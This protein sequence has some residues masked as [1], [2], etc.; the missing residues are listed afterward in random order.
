M[1]DSRASEGVPK[2]SATPTYG[3]TIDSINEPVGSPPE[4]SSDTKTTVEP[5]LN[6]SHSV[7]PAS[8]EETARTAA[9]DEE[10]AR[11]AH[12]QERQSQADARLELEERSRQAEARM[13][14]QAQEQR[15]R[16][17]EQ[18]RRV[19]RQ[20]QAEQSRYRAKQQA[21]QA[22]AQSASPAR[23]DPGGFLYED[24]DRNNG[25]GG[26]EGAQEQRR[27][28]AKPAEESA[29]S[30]AD[31]EYL[32]RPKNPQEREPSAAPIVTP[33]S[34]PSGS[35]KPDSKS[36]ALGD[37]HGAGAD[38]SSLDAVDAALQKLNWGQMAFDVP[39]TLRL[40]ETAVI[41]LLISPTHT[42]QQLTASIREQ[43]TEQVT[44]ESARVQISGMMEAKLV[45]G[46]FEIHSI[47]PD[48]P[49]MVS[50]TE[51]TQW[52][53]EIRP[54]QTGHQS[55]HLTLNAII[56]FD[57]K[58]RPRV[59]RTFDRVI[60]VEIA[61]AS[62]TSALN[63]WA[64]LG[65]FSVAAA[66][67]SWFAFRWWRRG[68]ERAGRAA[69]P[70]SASDNSAPTDLF[71]SYS[72]RDEDR[73]MPYVEKLRAV[74]FSVWIDQGG[75][76]GATL[77][78]QEISDAIRRARVCVLFGSTASFSSAHVTREV[79]L[80]C[81]EHKPIL[82]LHLD[83]VETPSAIR[84]QLAGIQHIPLYQGDWKANFEL[85]LRALKRLGVSAKL[86]SNPGEDGCAE[87]AC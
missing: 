16:Q 22:E 60:D 33:S 75:I 51:A 21:R 2:S 35:A 17:A 77:W 66:L 40:E 84:Y 5:S 20:A 65:A 86:T 70:T 72:R 3:R 61:S 19:V 81:E 79:A 87:K 74:G 69:P 26:E 9:L 31:A 59:V 24:E 73:V 53:W 4:S 71:L 18:A 56:R 28:E 64:T 41:H 1:S 23:V 68:L 58:E 32:K 54:R 27:R 80:A 39:E 57:D 55:L 10:T 25:L 29:R 42:A 14:R 63:G 12:E 83:L 30:D 13:E 15:E 67:V 62:K 78:A 76:D 11:R 38:D 37:G 45:G 46:S 47:T 52:K 50:R 34:S 82:P 36:D 7:P 8:A 6:P 48:E 49:Q 85:I 43:T 44:I